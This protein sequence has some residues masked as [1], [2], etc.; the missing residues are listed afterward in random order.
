MK[1]SRVSKSCLQKRDHL[2]RTTLPLQSAIKPVQLQ[3]RIFIPRKRVGSYFS[4]P[5]NLLENMLENLYPAL[6]R[7]S[8]N[9]D[10]S[11]PKLLRVSQP[12]AR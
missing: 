9:L 7:V 12:E 2:I 3:G 5:F 1:C 4:A 11:Q 6:L 8:P 10:S